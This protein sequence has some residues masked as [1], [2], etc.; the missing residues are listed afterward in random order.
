MVNE[1]IIRKLAL[2]FPESTESAHF[3]KISFRVRN[4]IFAT[5]DLKNNLACI[6]LTPVD[7][8]VFSAFDKS[9]I[10]P[11]SNQWGMQ[12]WTLVD[13]QRVRKDLFEDMLTCGFC[14]VAPAKLADQIR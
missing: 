4:K 6:R 7:Q 11:V 2:S 1:S 12:G 14:T 3:E 8:N 5:L 13:L 9:I 10:Y